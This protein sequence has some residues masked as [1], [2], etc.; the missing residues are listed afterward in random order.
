[1]LYTLS[2][3]LGETYWI[4]VNP[5]NS[6][7]LATAGYDKQ[8]KIYDKRCSPVARTFDDVHKSK[9]NRISV[10]FSSKYYSKTLELID[11]VRWNPT[12]D[13]L[14]TASLDSTAKILD[15]ASGKVYY[16]GFTSDESKI[17]YLIVSFYFIFSP[18]SGCFISVFRFT[19]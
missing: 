5:K 13:R 7:L 17:Y 16:K 6:N 12:G 18:F 9:N 10:L 1:M 19:E 15:F 11:C 2:S 8:V 4:D 14:A 3:I